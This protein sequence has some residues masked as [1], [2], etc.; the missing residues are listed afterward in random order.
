MN[1]IRNVALVG[2][3]VDFSGFRGKIPRSIIPTDMDGVI[4]LIDG[5]AENLF[6]FIEY[7]YQN[8]GE[9]W[10]NAE[11]NAQR[12][13]FERMVRVLKKGGAMAFLLLASHDTRPGKMI[14]GHEAIVRKFYG[15]RDFI[16]GKYGWV[17]GDGTTVLEW[18]MRADRITWWDRR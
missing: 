3:V 9:F 11:R 13:A 10:I 17:D 7:K 14:A 18:C 2:Q 4:A 1:E 12:D 16:T 5:E 8:T 15:A 6:I